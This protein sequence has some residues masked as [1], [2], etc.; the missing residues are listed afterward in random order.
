EHGPGRERT[1]HHERVQEL[2]AAVA[3]GVE[4]GREQLGDLASDPVQLPSVASAERRRAWLADLRGAGYGSDQFE[5]LDALPTE[6]LDASVQGQ[7]RVDRAVIGALP[8]V[9]LL[10]A[11]GEQRLHVLEVAPQRPQGHA[12]AF[13]DAFTGGP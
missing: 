4:L 9:Q 8:L 13:G 7:A 2:L 11:R 1:A 12:G 5:H 3:G 10:A 6:L